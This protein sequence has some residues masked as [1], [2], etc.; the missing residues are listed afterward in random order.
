MLTPKNTKD[1][2]KETWSKAFFLYTH[3]FP[4]SANQPMGKT[5]SALDAYGE[6]G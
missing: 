5:S 2:I 4:T 6:M 3:F 1:Q